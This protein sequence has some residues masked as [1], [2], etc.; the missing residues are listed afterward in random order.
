MALPADGHG[1]D[2]WLPTRVE[3]FSGGR[4]L[5][6]YQHPQGAHGH[7]GCTYQR[8]GI[9]IEFCREEV[10]NDL[11]CYTKLYNF[12]YSKYTYTYICIYTYC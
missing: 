7:K 3:Q 8:V 4:D 1:N 6:G 11:E 2:D 12:I 5:P 9:V 10:H